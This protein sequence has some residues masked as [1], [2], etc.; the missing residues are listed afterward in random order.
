MTGSRRQ[1]KSQT[2]ERSETMANEFCWI[3]MCTD[4]TGA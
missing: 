1:P 4:N 3:E 2:D